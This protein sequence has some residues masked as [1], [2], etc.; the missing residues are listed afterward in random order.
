MLL[1]YI[2][3]GGGFRI[4]TGTLFFGLSSFS[5]VPPGKIL[6]QYFTLGFI[7]YPFQFTIH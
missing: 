5:S 2:E 4:S 7:P 6:G 1:L 3:A